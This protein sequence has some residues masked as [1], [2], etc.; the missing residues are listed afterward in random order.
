MFDLSGFCV[1]IVL[2]KV[3]LQVTEDAFKNLDTFSHFG[4]V[5]RGGG[6]VYS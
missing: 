5:G 2:D 3:Y 6:V 4:G 1:R